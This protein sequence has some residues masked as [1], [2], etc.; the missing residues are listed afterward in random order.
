M[1]ALAK[2]EH[3]RGPRLAGHL[4][5]VERKLRGD[6]RAVLI[7]DRGHGVADEREVLYTGFVESNPQHRIN[8]FCYGLDNWLYLGSGASSGDI[9]CT[10]TGEV[11][12]VSGRDSRIRPDAGLLQA[13]S[14]ETQYG[15]SRDDW[16]NWF[17]NDNSHPLF[18]FVL[19]DR[20]LRRNP[21]VA[22][23]RAF[24]HVA[25]P[26]TA[27]PVFPTSRTVDRF[28]DLF[29]LD[30]FT[31]ACSESR[32]DSSSTSRSRTSADSF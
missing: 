15:R 26:P 7:H 27:P 10:K 1:A 31:S 6:R 12:N 25:D 29:A 28:N 4:N 20:D 17:G 16:G 24:V 19:S 14:G 22:S 2:P 8:G 32:R 30:R 18:H 9:T 11:V 23:P 5:T 21:F 13:E 3:L